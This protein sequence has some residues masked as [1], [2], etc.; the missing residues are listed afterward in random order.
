MPL[1]DFME[2]LTG[3]WMDGNGPESDTVISSRVRLARNLSDMPFPYL[4]SGEESEKI[5]KDTNRIIQENSS[6]KFE[7]INM[8]D[9]SSLG[10]KALVEKH[11]ISPGLA[12]NDNGAAIIREDET[13]SIMI[14]EEDH[15]RIQALHSGQQLE[16]A[17]ELCNEIDDILESHLNYA[18]SE[19]TGYLT[20]CP[21]NVGTGI[22]VSV[23]VH[24]PALIMTKQLNRIFSTISQVGLAVRGLY[25][26]G[27]QAVGNIYQISNQ[28]TLGQTEYEIIENLNGVTKQII[29]QEK[30][31]REILLKERKTKLSDKIGRSYGTISNAH[32]MS[33]DEA[34]KLLSDVRFGVELG[35]IKDI[36][37]KMINELMILISPAY[38]QELNGGELSPTD[39]DIKRADTIRKYF[40]SVNLGGV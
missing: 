24:L 16:T 33:S 36:N 32:I 26:E 31:V 7:L 17:W 20:A 9:I 19:E 11:L 10:R 8:R 25:G 28:I 14:N 34:M 29:E 21:T 1:R 12:E 15:L 38:L 6:E 5:I 39:R 30:S 27:T 35:L 18:F 13:V 3:K 37:L 4:M 23:M 2:K 22:R 40:A